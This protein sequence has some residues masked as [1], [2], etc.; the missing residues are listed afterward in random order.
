MKPV[1][2]TNKISRAAF[3]KIKHLHHQKHN[4]LPVSWVLL[5]RDEQ[6]HLVMNDKFCSMT[7]TIANSPG[8][9]KLFVREDLP[10]M[11]AFSHV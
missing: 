5:N 8:S 9:I 1:W 6:I 2:L 11:M 7:G 10:F 3:Y 4:L